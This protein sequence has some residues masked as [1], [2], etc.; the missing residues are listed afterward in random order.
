MEKKSRL[1]IIF[2]DFISIF[3]TF[4]RSG[5]LLGKFEVFFK[6][7]KVCTNPAKRFKKQ[8][9]LLQRVECSSVTVWWQITKSC[10]QWNKS[11][12]Y[13][14][15]AQLQ[16]FRRLW[17]SQGA[18]QIFDS[19]GLRFDFDFGSQGFL[20]TVQLNARIQ[21]QPVENSSIAVWTWPKPV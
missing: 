17:C 19:I 9:K 5:K 1:F 8:K 2:P 18:D 14:H 7:L 3:Q 4:S 15:W 6:N 21:F 16:I 13:F 20:W 11:F 12:T 10:Y